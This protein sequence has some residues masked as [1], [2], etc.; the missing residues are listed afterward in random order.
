[1]RRAERL[2]VLLLVAL[3]A[4]CGSDRAEREPVPPQIVQALSRGINVSRWFNHRGD[5]LH[6][7]E[8]YTPTQEELA[9]LRRAGLRHVRLTVDP[10]WLVESQARGRIS[11][12]AIAELI[13]GIGRI[14]S[15]GLVTV[16]V[17][18]PAEGTRAQI[19]EVEQVTESFAR[20]WRD[21]ALRLSRF[22]PDELVFEPLNEPETESARAAAR[23]YRRVTRAIREVAPLHSIVVSGHRWS[24]V[25]ELVEIEPLD[26]GN[27]VYGFHF[28][29]PANFTHQG[30]DWGW[31]MWKQL[32]GL[33]YPSSPEAVAELLSL[34][35]PETHPH[36]LHYGEQRWDRRKLAARLDLVRRWTVRHQRRVWCSEFGVFRYHVH[37][38]YRIRWLR[39][40][41]ELLEARQ[42][43]WSLWNFSGQFGLLQGGPGHRRADPEELRALGLDA[44]A[45]GG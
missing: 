16:L 42:I 4:G 5:P 6:T 31:P 22:S 34:L 45:F 32:A 24:G 13:A 2:V 40:V 26:D 21:L 1:M 3:A 28:Y 14:R 41:R 25:D 12:T 33:P 19:S 23:M 30:A 36:V 27:I 43:G 9:A 7:V 17:L 29:E 15:A 8:R 20:L 11:D 18:S 37:Q 44:R 35:P 10:A 39:D 38:Q